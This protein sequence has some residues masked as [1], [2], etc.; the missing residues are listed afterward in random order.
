MH[1]C[2]FKE[3]VRNFHFVGDG[4]HEVGAHVAAVVK[5]FHAAPDASPIALGELGFG[6]Y[7]FIVVVEASGGV[8][9]GPDLDF[10]GGRAIVEFVGCICGLGGYV[11]DLA[12][13]GYLFCFRGG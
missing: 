11:T 2:G 6:F 10:H 3:V 12:D 1:V 4:P 7:G 13:K 9:V 8:D 5:S